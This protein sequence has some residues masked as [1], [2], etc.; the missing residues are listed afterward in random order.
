MQLAEF[1]VVTDDV[2]ESRAVNPHWIAGC[3][4]W[5]SAIPEAEPR[6]GRRRCRSRVWSAGVIISVAHGMVLRDSD[7]SWPDRSRH[8]CL[9]LQQP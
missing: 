1:L 9:A 7:P 8:C 6:A 5:R 3:Q 2:V 4:S